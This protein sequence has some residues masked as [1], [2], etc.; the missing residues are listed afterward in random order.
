LLFQYSSLSLLAFEN[1]LDDTE[2]RPVFSLI[3]WTLTRPSRQ[4]I[5][6][7]LIKRFFLTIINDIIE[8]S[9]IESGKLTLEPVHYEFR[10]SISETVEIFMF[11]ANSKG[12]QLNL[13]VDKAIPKYVFADKGNDLQNKDLSYSVKELSDKAHTI[14][15][16]AKIVGAT[17]MA[18]CAYKLEISEQLDQQEIVNTLI[19]NIWTEL[20]QFKSEIKK[21][22]W[23]ESIGN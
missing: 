6:V 5:V 16:L 10:P 20:K 15:G 21:T 17:L 3:F 19:H 9:K 8:L 23:A 13:K 4:Y 11:K 22:K 7:V 1:E 14:K 18:D 2:F 12:I